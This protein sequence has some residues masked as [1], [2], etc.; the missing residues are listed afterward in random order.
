MWYKE[1]ETVKEDA[2]KW[3]GFAGDR[4]VLEIRDAKTTDA[5]LYHVRARNAHG[6]TTSFSQL[7]VEDFRRLSIPA[8]LQVT[9]KKVAPPPPPKPVSRPSSV[10]SRPPSIQ[11]ALTNT[12]WEEGKTA[13]LQ[14]FTTGEPRPAVEWRFNNVPIKETKDVRIQETVTLLF[15]YNTFSTYRR[16]AGLD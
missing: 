6:E 5:G 8:A 15:F 11:P 7:K 2:R 16:M 4:C 12:T 9:S 1:E 14:V 10:L 3:L 13:T